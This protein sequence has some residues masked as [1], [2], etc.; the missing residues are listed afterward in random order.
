MSKSKNRIVFA[1][2]A[3]SI[4]TGEFALLGIFDAEEK[5]QAFIDQ[6]ELPQRNCLHIHPWTLNHYTSEDF[7]QKGYKPE[8]PISDDERL[9]RMAALAAEDAEHKANEAGQPFHREAFVAEYRADMLRQCAEPEA[10]R[11]KRTPE[12][13]SELRGTDDQTA[14]KI[15][16]EVVDE[17]P[18]HE[19]NI[20][21]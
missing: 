15:A 19:S 1:V 20:N 13:I 21:E 5:A 6:V 14:G 8:P 3:L 10:E 12:P 9:A 7:W 16:D 18:G 17:N 2:Q 4:S 11:V